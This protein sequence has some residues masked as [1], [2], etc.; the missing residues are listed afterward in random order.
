MAVEHYTEVVRKTKIADECMGNF[1]PSLFGMKCIKVEIL[2]F[3]FMDYLSPDYKGG[4]WAFCRLSNGGFFMFPNRAEPFCIKVNGNGFSG[5]LSAEAAG[6]V[7]C[8]FAL[9]AFAEESEQGA[10]HYHLLRDFAIDHPEAGLIF[11]AID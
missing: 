9:C 5:E 2:V 3:S 10:E 8:L 4:S 11:Q 1:L 7:A 6:I